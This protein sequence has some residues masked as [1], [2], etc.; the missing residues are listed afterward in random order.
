VIV[1]EADLI[2]VCI[3]NNFVMEFCYSTLYFRIK[4]SF[5]MKYAFYFYFCFEMFSILLLTMI[6]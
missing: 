5:L 1:G 4:S 6:F 3:I 2:G